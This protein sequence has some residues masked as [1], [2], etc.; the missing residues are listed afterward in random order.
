VRHAKEAALQDIL[1]GSARGIAALGFPKVEQFHRAS[2]TFWEQRRSGQLEYQVR[3]TPVQRFQERGDDW[4]DCRIE[5]VTDDATV[6][7]H[8]VFHVDGRV[9]AGFPIL[10]SNGEEGVEVGVL[11]L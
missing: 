1:L 4:I 8:L 10:L 3:L 2:E 9:E 11:R 5:I 6:E 7:S